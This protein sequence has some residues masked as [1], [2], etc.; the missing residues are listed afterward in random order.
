[1]LHPAYDAPGLPTQPALYVD[2]MIV[3]GVNVKQHQSKWDDS[4]PDRIFHEVRIH[5]GRCC[6]TVHTMR[7]M[8]RLYVAL[9]PPTSSRSDVV[10]DTLCANAIVLVSEH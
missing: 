4:Q 10:K 9:L 7:R 3:V 6:F 1:M 8:Q 2:N 5:E